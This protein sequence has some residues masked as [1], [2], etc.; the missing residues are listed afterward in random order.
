MGIAHGMKAFASLVSQHFD[1]AARSH[2]PVHLGSSY[3]IF[4]FLCL[5]QYC[6]GMLQL[7]RRR[8]ALLPQSNLVLQLYDSFLG[9]LL[10]RLKDSLGLL[11][12]HLLHRSKTT[13]SSGPDRVVYDVIDEPVASE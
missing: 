5:G 7:S 4:H 13:I 1:G 11:D 10:E 2:S 6:P 9:S 3:T 8:T 12:N